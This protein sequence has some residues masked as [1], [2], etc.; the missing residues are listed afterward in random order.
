M[1]TQQDPYTCCVQEIHLRMKDILTLKAKAWK[2]LFHANGNNNNNKAEIDVLVSDK[3]D[4]KTKATI[5]DIKGHY[6]MIEGSV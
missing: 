6:I 1:K 2:K 4:F 3:I 5:K